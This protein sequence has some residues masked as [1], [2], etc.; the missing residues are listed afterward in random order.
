MQPIKWE[1]ARKSLANSLT[2]EWVRFGLVQ[3]KLLW[4]LK[5]IKVIEI[6]Q[7]A[8]ASASASALAVAWW[9]QSN[10]HFAKRQKLKSPSNLDGRWN[11]SRSSPANR[12]EIKSIIRLKALLKAG[13][14]TTA[15][16][17]TFER[18]KGP[19]VERK[20]MKWNEMNFDFALLPDQ[21]L[22]FVDVPRRAD[23]LWNLNHL[24]PQPQL[25]VSSPARKPAHLFYNSSLSVWFPNLNGKPHSLAS[26]H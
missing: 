13:Q 26:C 18:L 12:N 20:M 23:Q 16:K 25:Q 22:F 17:P 10:F 8:S 3:S 15:S 6:E 14:Q 2:C 4:F 9:N 7:Q 5:V 19:R 21:P 24:Q 1:L 11:F